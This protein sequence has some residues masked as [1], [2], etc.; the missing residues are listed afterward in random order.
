M[1]PRS[2]SEIELEGPI[3]RHTSQQTASNILSNDDAD[4]ESIQKNK[5]KS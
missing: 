5:I 2:V 1:L 4:I 3:S